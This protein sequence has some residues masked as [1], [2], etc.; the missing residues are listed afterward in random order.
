[1]GLGGKCARLHGHRY[2]VEVCLTL[3]RTSN[4]VTTLFSD[5]DM[6]LLPIFESLDHKTLLVDSDPLVDILIGEA[7]VFK[8]ATSAENLAAWL[9]SE[10]IA[11]MGEAVCS[12]ALQETDSS[13][14]IATP[15]DLKEFPA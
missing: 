8:F 13:T 9:L 4:G 14:V 6:K 10:C 12:L 7:V 11:A 2:G 15:D 1:M 3:P 5:I